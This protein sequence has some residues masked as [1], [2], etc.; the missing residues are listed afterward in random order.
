[1]ERVA[2]GYATSSS[3]S[4]RV[5][6][7]R[8][9]RVMVVVEEPAAGR[10]VAVEAVHLA[11]VEALVDAE[12]EAEPRRGA[13]MLR[14]QAPMAAHGAEAEAVGMASEAAEEKAGEVLREVCPARKGTRR[15]RRRWESLGEAETHG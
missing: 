1:V 9:R 13:L 6:A 11:V 2:E 5:T 12:A 15:R 10:A 4:S 8:V 7:A 14:G 3:S